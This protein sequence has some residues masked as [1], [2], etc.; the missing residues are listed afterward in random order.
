[1][2]GYNARAVIESTCT[3]EELA[4]DGWM[5]YLAEEVFDGDHT[6]PSELGLLVLMA[7]LDPEYHRMMREIQVED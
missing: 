2:D 7:E 5:L 3:D 6:E 1:M 4:D